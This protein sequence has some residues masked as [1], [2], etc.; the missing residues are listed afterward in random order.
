MINEMRYKITVEPVLNRVFEQL[1]LD[2]NHAGITQEELDRAVWTWASDRL[3]KYPAPPQ[4]LATVIE[5]KTR[6]RDADNTL[7]GETAGL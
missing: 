6:Q 7:D 3:S 1:S 4:W 2:T 5:E